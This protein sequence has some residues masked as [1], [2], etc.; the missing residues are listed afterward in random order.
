MGESLTKTNKTKK[1]KPMKRKA[2]SVAALLQ[3]RLVE[4][5]EEAE[6]VRAIIHGPPPLE[7]LPK[8]AAWVNSCYHAPSPAAIRMEALNEATRGFGVETIH[9]DDDGL[10]GQGTPVLQYVNQGDTYAATIVRRGVNR[11]AISCWG[12]EVEKLERRGVKV[13]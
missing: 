5:R 1:G 11:Y 9:A 4:T 13:K 7:R 12:D 6:L 3:N 10:Y 2:P 8:T